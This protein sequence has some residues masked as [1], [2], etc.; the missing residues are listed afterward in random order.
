MFKVNNENFHIAENPYNFRY[1]SKTKFKVDHVNTEILTLFE[2]TG[3]PL[4]FVDVI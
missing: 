3:I 2:P 4:K 1:G